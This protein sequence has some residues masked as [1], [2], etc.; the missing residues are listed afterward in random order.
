M[1]INCSY[2]IVVEVDGRV[3][4]YTGKIVSIDDDFITFIDKFGK[5]F[6]YNKNK[7][8]STEEIGK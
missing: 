4:T 5:T 6:S 8:I 3:L 2:K 1:K 7:I